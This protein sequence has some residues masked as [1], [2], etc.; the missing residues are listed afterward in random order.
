[1]TPQCDAHIGVCFRGRM[2]TAESDTAVWC[3]SKNLTPRDDAQRRVWLHS[4]MHTTEFFFIRIS[5]RGPRWFWIIKNGGQKSHD[6]LPLKGAWLSGGMHTAS[7]FI[8]FVFMTLQCDSHCGVWLR[9]MMHTNHEKNGGRNS[10]D[11]LPLPL[12]NMC[13][14]LFGY[15]WYTVRKV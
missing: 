2:H 6:T 10:R 13:N 8:Y 11:I 4:R 5:Q 15:Y 7:F 14:S 1:M 9:G 3:A 12:R